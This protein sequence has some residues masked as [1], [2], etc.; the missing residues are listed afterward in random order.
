MVQLRPRD[1]GRG[2]RLSE[3]V[4][5]PIQ[6]AVRFLS[7]SPPLSRNERGAAD[8]VL[9]LELGAQFV[10]IQVQAVPRRVLGEFAPLAVEDAP[11]HG[12]QPDRPETLVFLPLLVLVP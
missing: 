7:S 3:A 12:G 8:P 5:E 11:A 2:L 9:G 10:Q 6:D 4:Q 1:A